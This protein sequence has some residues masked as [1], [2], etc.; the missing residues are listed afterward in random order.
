MKQYRSITGVILWI[1]FFVILAQVIVALAE[2]NTDFFLLTSPP[3]FYPAAIFLILSILSSVS[4]SQAGRDLWPATRSARG[5]ML[6]GRNYAVTAGILVILTFGAIYFGYAGVVPGYF[7]GDEWGFLTYAER[8]IDEFKQADLTPEGNIRITGRLVYILEHWI[9]GDN[10][11]CYQLVNIALHTANALLVAIFMFLLTGK[12]DTAFISCLLFGLHPG[13]TESV[14]FIG[15]TF[16]SLCL[17]FSLGS[18]V[19]YLERRRNRL[20]FPISLCSFFLAL[21]SKEIAIG[22]PLIVFLLEFLPGFK[23][24]SL[25]SAEISG[26]RWKGTLFFTG[27]LLIYFIARFSRFGGLGGYV[28]EAGHSV[29]LQW[30]RIIDVPVN[31]WSLLSALALPLNPN[32]MQNYSI[33]MSI[34]ILLILSIL[35][36]VAHREIDWRTVMLGAGWIFCG[37]GSGYPPDSFCGS[38]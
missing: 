15:N 5:P 20:F 17:L 34:G 4:G 8:M 27:V 1:L 35:L 18:L 22:I 33:L 24:W 10:P 12:R 21:L 30:S 7:I 37:R 36:L 14:S 32:L 28:D 29:F 6:T 13:I 3:I 38:C 23:G 25:P 31:M 19:L 26:S 11:A 9:W 16:D 2:N